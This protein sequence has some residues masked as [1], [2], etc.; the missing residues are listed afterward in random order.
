MPTVLAFVRLC[1]RYRTS[2][3]FVVL[4]SEYS[5]Q[6]Y[7]PF[8]KEIEEDCTRFRPQHSRR[9]VWIMVPRSPRPCLVQPW[10]PRVR[11]QTWP[12]FSAVSGP[13]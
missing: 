8:T 10:I 4:D 6:H 13:I 12:Q 5:T 3:A 9:P 11:R 2:T 1:E 7:K